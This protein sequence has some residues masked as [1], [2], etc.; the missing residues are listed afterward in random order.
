[1]K[2]CTFASL[3]KVFAN[4]SLA[5]FFA[6]CSV[7]MANA[8]T[9]VS[10]KVVDQNGAALPGVAVQLVE[11]SSIGTVTDVDG[12]YAV[13]ATEKNTLRFSSIGYVTLEVK[14]GTQ[15][16]INVT[17][18]E[19]Y[20]ELDDAVVIGY[21]TA[22][23]ADLTGSTSSLSGE[24]LSVKSNPQLS[25]QLQGQMAGVQVTRSGGNPADGATIRVRG[26]TTMS[27]ND[28]L[29]IIDGIP[30]SLN[31]VAPEDVKDI[32]VLKD[33]AS[34]AIYGSRAAA[35]VI[36]VTTKRAKTDQFKLSY[37][38]EYGIDTPTAVP[39]F[40]GAVDWMIGMNEIQQNAGAALTYSEDYINTYAENH[41]KDPNLYPDTDWMGLGLKKRTGHQNH[42]LTISGG[43]KN[44]KSNLS[45]G[46]YA[47]DGLVKNKDYKRVNVR[48]N[49]DWKINNWIH[50]NADIFLRYGLTHS[51][52]GGIVAEL[53]DRGP[54]Y[55]AYWDDGEYAF[56]KSGDNP[57][58]KAEL[59]GVNTGRQHTIQGKFQIDL[60]PVKG[61]TITALASP[62]FYFYKGKNHQTAYKLR[63]LSGVYTNSEI[64]STN[65][66]EDRNDSYNLTMQL[67]ANYKIDIH[68]HSLGVMAGYE[69]FM[70]RWENVQAKRTNYTL[71]NYPYLDLGP[72]DFQFNSGSAGHNAYRSF[73]GRVMYSYAGKYMVQANI[74]ADG[75]SRFAPG[76][77]WGVFPS[78]SAGWVMSEEDWFKNDVVNFF[79]IRASY[80]QLGN[81]R[82]GS[83]FPYQAALQFGTAFLPN[84]SGVTDVTQTA[85]QMTYAFKDITWETTTTYGVG[86]D[87]NM[88]RNRLRLNAD[89][90][91][92][93][94][95]N[96]L[97]EIGFPSYFGYNSPQYNSADMNTKGWDL[98]LSWS[99][100]VG[101]FAYGVSAN[102]SDYRSRMGYMANKSNIS[103]GKITEEGS[104]YQE[105]FGYQSTGIIQTEADMPAAVLG[106]SDKPGCLG[107]VDQPTVDTDGDGVPDAGDGIINPSGD[108]VKLGNSL[109]EYLYGASFWANW[110]GFDF[111]LS[112]QGIG[113]RLQKWT[114]PAS[115][116]WAH[117]AYAAPAEVFKYRWSPNATPEQ[118]AKAKYPMLSIQNEANI[119]AD[120]DFW[121][122]NAGYMRVKNITLGYTIPER[123]TKKAAI[124]NLRF[125]FSANDLPAISKFPKGYDPEWSRGGSDFILSSYVF[126]LNITF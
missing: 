48:S 41:A 17:L 94:T 83:E 110:K 77:R 86:V 126:G 1:M 88:F 70:H 105:W 29:V 53:M 63:E 93:K 76:Y 42:S 47:S 23:K 102:L 125:Y 52:Q 118:N 116:P 122:F 123:I 92:K 85:Y 117:S 97:L 82:I 69:D 61:L 10:G 72:A 101:E 54:I 59:G 44:L 32:Q 106:K 84:T 2:K 79:K 35:G 46:Y 14:V 56:A 45:L 68:D 12:Y 80:G 16:I 5:L 31:D 64:A 87:L 11:N 107:F 104:Y 49:N 8:Q 34:A 98:E 43:S 33:A 25:S 40:L 15:T 30:G 71:T 121:L 58:A 119:H 51:P 91:Y 100:Q 22:R 96:M 6:V 39:E 89:V 95:E 37:N 90:Y 114:W 62:K 75:S 81:E 108:R 111:N 60:T 19:D 7:A 55:A 21:G 4:A 13:T 74:R 124:Q 26:V 109:P 103:G 28:P 57:I 73:F 67:Y 65:L 115:S 120:C 24:R 112:L 3:R 36:L 9:R 20:D 78:V 99:D 38:F 50:V 18:N 66:T 27:T 113:R